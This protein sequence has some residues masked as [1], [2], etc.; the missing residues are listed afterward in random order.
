M[1]TVGNRDRAQ[2]ERSF[3]SLLLDSDGPPARSLSPVR[4]EEKKV[5]VVKVPQCKLPAVYLFHCSS[6]EEIC[7]ALLRERNSLLRQALTPVLRDE[8]FYLVSVEC[9]CLKHLLQDLNITFIYTT[10]AFVSI[11]RQFPN[12]HCPVNHLGSHPEPSEVNGRLFINF[13]GCWIWIR[14]CIRLNT[15]ATRKTSLLFMYYLHIPSTPQ[16]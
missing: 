15:P 7:L 6:P 1:K 5:M 14:L 16:A 9:S 3:C 4:R 8:D 11:P 10:E 12:N 2:K 13:N